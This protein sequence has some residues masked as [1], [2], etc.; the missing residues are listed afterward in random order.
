MYALADAHPW[1]DEPVLH[2]WDDARAAGILGNI[3][4][5]IIPGGR[6]VIIETVM[7]PGNEYHHAK[8]LD[9]NMLVLSEGGRE[10]TEEG[11]YSARDGIYWAGECFGRCGC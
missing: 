2:D 3:R 4:N 7:P 8:F 1:D 9:L 5:A 6:L 11:S 10:R